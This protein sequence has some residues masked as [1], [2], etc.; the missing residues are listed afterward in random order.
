MASHRTN[1]GSLLSIAG[2]KCT[3]APPPAPCKGRPLHFGLAPPCTPEA[4]WAGSGLWCGLRHPC[5]FPCTLASPPCTPLLAPPPLRGVQ[6][7]ARGCKGDERVI[8]GARMQDSNLDPLAAHRLCDLWQHSTAPGG[9]DRKEEC[10]WL[11]AVTSCSLVTVAGRR[12]PTWTCS[13][14]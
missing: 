10:A 8:D 14:L 13:S 3:L 1:P 5:T 9:G 4:E 12:F 7:S 2:H 11:G 6:A